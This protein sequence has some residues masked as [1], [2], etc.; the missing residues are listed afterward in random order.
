MNS[1]PRAPAVICAL[2]SL[3][4]PTSAPAQ[5]TGACGQTL[6][7]TETLPAPFSPGFDTLRQF[8]Q[9]RRSEPRYV[10]FSLREPQGVTVRTEAPGVDPAL[11]L[12]DG[13]GQLVGWDD[14]GGGGVDA[15]VA[16][17]LGAGAYCVQVRPIGAT[18]TDF[19]EIVLVF[20]SGLVVPPGEEVPCGTAA[21][22]DLAFGLAAP[23][24]PLAIDDTIEPGTGRRDFRLSLAEPLG[25]RID[26]ASGEFDTVLEVFDASGA[27]VAY[28]DDHTGTDSRIEVALAPG[29]Y[30]VVSRSFGGGDGAFSMALSEAAVV[31][32]ALPCGDPD[33]TGLLAEGFGMS[34]YAAVSS[35]IDPDTLRSW[36]RLSLAEGM[37]VRLDAASSAID[38]VLEV[39]DASGVLVADNDDGPDGTDSRIETALPSGDY[40]VTVR[41]FGDGTGPFD[42]TVVP[43]GMEPPEPQVEQP[44]PATASGV[45]DMGV[46]RDVVR[47]YTI[48]GEATLWASFSL[49]AP[50][51]VTVNGMSVSSRFSIA[52]FAE[53]GSLVGDAGP[54]DALSPADVVSDLSPGRYLVA[55]TNHGASGTILRQITVTRD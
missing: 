18:P 39:Y 22:R 29:D 34:S 21:T 8:V 55:L 36:Y 40:C 17:D 26:L 41:G 44:D 13:S 32:D 9:I 27:Q 4:L 15:L 19:T 45:E 33:R 5:T 50:A 16:L 42:L 24:D 30:C 31:A 35:E 49:E 43:A 37:E 10:E 28:N 3:A 12:Y 46:L 11:A 1:S 52:V 48:G 25:L 6:A 23:V 38:T 51:S 7:L 20:E 53:D 47:S 14:D 2:L 54:V